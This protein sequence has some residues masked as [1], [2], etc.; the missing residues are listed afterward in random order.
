MASSADQ[1]AI[2]AWNLLARGG[3]IDWAGLDV[4]VE[5][6]GVADVPGLL[7][8]LLVIKTYKKPE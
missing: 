4:V 1:I 2:K 6:L 3:G 5:L 7:H 8:R